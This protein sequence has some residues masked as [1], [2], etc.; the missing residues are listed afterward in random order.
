MHK[1]A[2]EQKKWRNKLSRQV[3][4]LIMETGK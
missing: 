1:D 2:H 4:I 3:F